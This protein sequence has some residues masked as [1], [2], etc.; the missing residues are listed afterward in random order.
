MR[1]RTRHSVEVHR[2]FTLVDP[3]WAK[4]HQIRGLGSGEGLIE[5]VK[6][7]PAP[8]GEAPVSENGD[9]KGLV[10]NNGDVFAQDD[11][12]VIK[13]GWWSLEPDAH[14]DKRYVVVESEFGRLLI[15]AERDGSTLAPVICQAWDSDVLDITTRKF[16]AHGANL[17]VSLLGHITIEGLRRQLTKAEALEG[18]AN[19]FLFFL[20]RNSGKQLPFGGNLQREELNALARKVRAAI[21][22]AREMTG[23]LVW[24]P[25]AEALY[26]QYYDEMSKDEP[27]GLLGGIV[28]RNQPQTLRLALTYALT[29]QEPRRI[30][31]P[32]LRAAK[33]VWDYC[34]TSAVYIFGDST[35]DDVAE[36]IRTR[37]IEIDPDPLY[38]DSI[39]RDLFQKNETSGRIN[40][41]LATLQSMGVI[42]I[43]KELTGQRGRPPEAVYLAGRR[44]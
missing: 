10:V 5:K 31:V 40:L 2:L 16:S 8:K 21:R 1:A 24:T 43:F 3:F 25:G 19:R 41:A 4:D 38:R 14:I 23:P 39:Y 32:H 35:G 44:A 33:A 37:L 22:R 15:I 42:E 34:R 26:E 36:R 9:E 20:V 12:S 6:D 11:D 29:D 30:D 13:S 17:H 28:A 7:P 18:F 27:G